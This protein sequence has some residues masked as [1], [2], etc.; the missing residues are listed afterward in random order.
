MLNKIRNKN[1]MMFNIKKNF[2]STKYYNNINFKNTR[3]AY[4]FMNN[5]DL[6]QQHYIYKL[7]NLLSS[8]ERIGHKLINSFMNIKPPIIYPIVQDK[9]INQFCGG[10]ILKDL[11]PIINKL[12][13]ANIAPLLNYGV[14]YT[15]SREELD[16][17]R[18]EMF[19]MIDY[20]HDKKSGQSI[21]RATGIM[22]HKRLAKVQANQKLSLS[23]EEEWNY[24]LQ[25]MEDI[26][27]YAVEKNVPLLFDA[28]T[29]DIQSEIHKQGIRMMK[30]FNTSKP[31]IYTTIQFY[32]KDSHSQLKSLINNAKKNNYVAGL[33]LV[34]GAYIHDETI[35]NRRHIIHDTKHET[36]FSY[37]RGVDLCIKNHDIIASF[38]ATHN[39]DTVNHI[40]YNLNKYNIEPF[41]P[42]I[43][44]AQMYGMR[45]D[46][47][48]NLNN[49]N[50][51]QF[52]PYGKKS[53]LFPYLVR[54][55]IENSSALGGA[56]QELLLVKK[57]LFRRK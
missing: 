2:F 9:L 22:S 10:V 26:C 49:I 32:R 18:D 15:T 23:E 4:R 34:R 53:F 8:N 6:K 50:V 1:Y 12:K 14:E 54:R 42:Y 30:K 5:N 16:K 41:S 37:N 24:D 25:R 52:I 55:G 11:D 27:K 21:F 36:D 28:E 48:F 19:N 7:F 44:I 13:E 56:K 57:E 39:L 43:I 29:S 3:N 31:H 35:S 20:L 47:T 40:I 51:S 38:F 46:I 33:K 45:R 17:S